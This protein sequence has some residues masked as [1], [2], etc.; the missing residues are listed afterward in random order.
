MQDI[1]DGN[2]STQLTSQ[3]SSMPL[4]DSHSSNCLTQICYEYASFMG[5]AGLMLEGFKEMYDSGHGCP[6]TDY[7][8]LGYD[9]TPGTANL[10]TATALAQ[11]ARAID[12]WDP[13]GAARK[14]RPLSPNVTQAPR[15]LCHTWC[16][17]A[18]LDMT[19]AVAQAAGW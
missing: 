2:L 7:S 11:V 5:P 10:A 18:H 14:A 12:V 19:S 16:K 1:Y 13:D 9:A 15:S 17:C 8:N 6:D 4:S 3:L